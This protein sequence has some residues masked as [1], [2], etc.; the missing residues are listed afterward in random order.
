MKRLIIL[1]LL[2][3]SCA[4]CMLPRKEHRD[5][6]AQYARPEELSLSISLNKNDR[7]FNVVL[8]NI[9]KREVYED[10]RQPGFRLFCIDAGSNVTVLASDYYAR[11]LYSIPK[12]KPKE[13]ISYTLP[14]ESFAFM[15]PDLLIRDCQVF[16]EYNSK[17]GSTCSNT[18]H[19][20]GPLLLG[21]PNST[22][23]AV[24]T[25]KEANKTFDATS[26]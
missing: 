12:M 18:I 14:C 22:Y 2:S 10:Y 13:T 6:S 3:F 16:I 9:G 24:T 26:Q 11:G 1:V 15:K 21:T 5:L 23:R 19:I 25:T 17:Y 4:G 20:D 7:A 8:R